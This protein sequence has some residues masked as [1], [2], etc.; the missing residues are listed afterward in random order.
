MSIGITGSWIEQEDVDRMTPEIYE[1]MVQD[2][3]G[4]MHKRGRKPKK[5]ATMIGGVAPWAEQINMDIFLRGFSSYYFGYAPACAEGPGRFKLKNGHD[6]DEE[7]LKLRAYRFNEFCVKCYKPFDLQYNDIIINSSMNGGICW[8][9]GGWKDA[10]RLIAYYSRETLLC[11]TWADGT[12]PVDPYV[13]GI[14]DKCEAPEK[15]HIPLQLIEAGII[16]QMPEKKKR[17][18]KKKV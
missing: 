16:T 6:E 18:T 8:C 12:E 17:K 1:G 10:Q 2:A 14:W 5:T 13:R 3:I 4:R 9:S 7:L 15:V 11:Y